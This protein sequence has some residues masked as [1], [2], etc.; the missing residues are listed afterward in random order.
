MNE[1][2]APV[3]PP[4]PK[5]TGRIL[6]RLHDFDFKI[7][8][9][10]ATRF[11]PFVLYV[12]LWVIIYIANHH[13]GEKTLGRID[14]TRKEMKDL[15]ADFYT[16]NAELSN[17]SIQSEVKKAVEPYGLKELSA[18]PQRIKLMDNNER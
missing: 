9:E 18:P 8:E 7:N 4:P 11:I 13:Y 2:K 16:I 1:F 10:N 3:Q 17:K 15:K 5:P 14:K 6:K 12:S